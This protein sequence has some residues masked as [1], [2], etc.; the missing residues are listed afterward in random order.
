MAVDERGGFRLTDQT[1]INKLVESA[2]QTVKVPRSTP[3]GHF[4]G[5][6]VMSDGK[7]IL[8][9]YLDMPGKLWMEGDKMLFS[10]HIPVTAVFEFLE[11]HKHQ[12]EFFDIRSRKE[13][14]D[15]T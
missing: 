11:D 14:N 5:R 15:S 10:F 2:N 6:V 1:L 8:D 4:F 13:E 12:V 3:Y 9:V 7:Q